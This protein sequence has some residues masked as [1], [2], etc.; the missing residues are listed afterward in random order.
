MP[1]GR[2]MPIVIFTRV[3]FWIGVAV[4]VIV[5]LLLARFL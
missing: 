2:C 4:G 5:A 1:N 3:D